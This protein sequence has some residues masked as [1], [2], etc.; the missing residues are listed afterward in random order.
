MVNFTDLQ[1]IQCSQLGP[2][3]LFWTVNL[4]TF[5]DD[6]VSWEIHTPSQCSCGHQNLCKNKLYHLPGLNEQTLYHIHDL[7]KQLLALCWYARLSNIYILGN[8]IPEYV[9][10]QTNPPPKSYPLD[11]FLHGEWQNRTAGGLSTPDSTKV[12]IKG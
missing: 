1:N 12:R 4:S 2:S 3:A 10:Q 8:E 11:S 9:C 7:Q 5:D 6:G